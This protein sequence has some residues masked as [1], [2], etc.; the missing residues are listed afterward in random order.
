VGEACVGAGDCR[1]F[2]VA[3]DTC[4]HS[5]CRTHCDEGGSC[6]SLDLV[7]RPLISGGGICDGLPCGQDLGGRDAH[8]PTGQ[9]CVPD[10]SGASESW[11]ARCSPAR[12]GLLTDGA[13]CDDDQSFMCEHRMCT[14]DVCSH[15]CASDADCSSE[16]PF[17]AVR[18]TDISNL[19]TEMAACINPPP[20]AQACHSE[21]ECGLL[22]CQFLDDRSA[23][24]ACTLEGTSYTTDP[25]CAADRSCPSKQVCLP[26]ADEQYRCTD[27][28]EVGAQCYASERC[29]SG[30]CIDRD[31]VEATAVSSRASYC[32]SRCQT[33]AD[34][35]LNMT[36]R[37]V[38]TS[39]SNSTG[40]PLILHPMCWPLAPP[41]SAC[42]TGDACTDGTTCDLATGACYT[43]GMG[44][45]Y[46][47]VQDAD[48][49]LGLRCGSPTGIPN[50]CV[51]EGCIPS[52]E[53]TGCA[54]DEVCVSTGSITAE[55]RRVCADDSDCI[56]VNSS[57]T[58][59]D[60]DEFGKRS[61]NTL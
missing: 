8:C 58:C 4:R 21:A 15:L 38:V 16:A 33:A 3:L 35:G 59:G 57:L 29:R 31:G 42:T 24:S 53:S 39:E 56:A 25:L 55:C 54:P 61:C 17:C 18:T 52:T 5:A 37:N 10:V 46:P 32:S 34:C 49:D 36:C 9:V 50:A 47:C 6:P 44:S 23:F 45:G 40:L 14:S 13:P 26:A 30:V 27:R 2:E 11:S 43:P 7:C 28:L 20:D 1:A 60:A 48:C 51:R 12:S 41:T 19:T 22:G